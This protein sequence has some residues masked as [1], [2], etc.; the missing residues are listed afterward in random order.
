MGRE[1]K[2]MQ[3]PPNTNANVSTKTKVNIC[4]NTTLNE[5]IEQLILIRNPQ[6]K[7]EGYGVILSKILVYGMI[8]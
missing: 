2:P 4:F 1:L 5:K 6:L 8:G 3:Q 7:L